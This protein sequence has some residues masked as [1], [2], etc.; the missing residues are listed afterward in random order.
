ML[1]YVLQLIM[2]KIEE[3]K[4]HPL[5]LKDKVVLISLIIIA[6]VLTILEYHVIS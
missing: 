2:Q 3:R 1:H 6:I 5:T 4:E